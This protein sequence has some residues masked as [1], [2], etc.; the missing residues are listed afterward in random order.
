[1]D[2]IGWFGGEN[3]HVSKIVSSWQNR[4]DENTENSMTI[5]GENGMCGIAEVFQVVGKNCH[6]RGAIRGKCEPSRGSTFCQTF[7]AQPKEDVE[8]RHDGQYFRATV[9]FDAYSPNTFC[10]GR[11]ACFTGKHG[12][13]NVAHTQCGSCKS[14]LQPSPSS[15][16]PTMTLGMSLHTR[17]PSQPQVNQNALAL[18]G[19]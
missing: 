16:R 19:S 18:D 14:L 3:V 11:G 10:D 17:R 4:M 1:M 7:G 9:V 5:V 8:G 15:L 6:P 13:V 2:N 12:R